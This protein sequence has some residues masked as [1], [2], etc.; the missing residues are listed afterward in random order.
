MIKLEKQSGLPLAWDSA[1]KRLVFGEGMVD[2]DPHIYGKEDIRDVLFK[3]EEDIPDC[4]YQVYR[5][6]ALEADLP[7]IELQGIRY[8]IMVLRPGTIGR[9]Y[10]KTI[11]N[12]TPVKP[13]ASC[14]YP[15]IFE[16]L[17][18]RAH[19]LLQSPNEEDD[20]DI[21]KV[22]LIN[23]RPGDKVLVYPGFGHII[24]NPEDSYLIM[25]NLVVRDVAPESS[26]LL[27]RQGGCYYELSGDE[28]P[29]FLQNS[30]YNR[31]PSLKRCPVKPAPALKLQTGLP[32]YQVFKE[33]PVAFSFLLYP[34]NYQELFTA[35]LKETLDE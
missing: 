4:I 32:V 34:E 12:Y 25:S 28:G 16:V 27:Q 26:L 29:V 8:D 21:E 3:P 30:R 13:G 19:F 22:M 15:E 17:H 35:H 18:G 10:I 31:L 24:I 7:E 23:A 2:K 5:D 9:E 1:Q 33:D 14:T 11:G 6:I 20:G